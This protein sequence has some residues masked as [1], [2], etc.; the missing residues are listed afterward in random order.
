[1]ELARGQ[2]LV[3]AEVAR[4]VADAPPHRHVAPRVAAEDLDAPAGGAD[5]VE[6]QPDRRRLAGAVRA[7]E[8]E[9]LARGHGEVEL[10]HAPLRAVQLR[11]P[12]GANRGS[13]LRHRPP[14]PAEL[15]G[16]ALPD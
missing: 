8:A 1:A 12:E 4:Q 16:D 11:Q 5:Q 7:E 3:E 9:H 2:A 15:L 6:E 13:G 10:E 14:L